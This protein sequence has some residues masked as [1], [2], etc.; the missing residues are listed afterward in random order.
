MAV[1]AAPEPARI[2]HPAR[3]ECCW[4][5]ELGSLDKAAAFPRDINEV[6]ALESLCCRAGRA[7]KRQRAWK[8]N[9]QP[10]ARELY[11]DLKL[12]FCSGRF[13]AAAWFDLVGLGAGVAQ[14][15]C[16]SAPAW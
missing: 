7:G 14:L 15:P 10:R 5:L 1:L 16:A 11:L 12:G 6:Q 8:N 2:R 3:Q 4:A 9:C 13:I